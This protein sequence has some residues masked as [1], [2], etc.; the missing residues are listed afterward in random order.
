MKQVRVIK[1]LAGAAAM[2][3]ASQAYGAVVVDANPTNIIGH[4]PT[5][6]D[7]G[8]RVNIDVNGDGQRDL[9]I[10]YRN[11]SAT[12]G[13]LLLGYIYAGAGSTNPG[14]T[15]AANVSGQAYSYNLAAGTLVGAASSFY[16][17]AGYF[18]HLV[19]NYAGT[20]YGVGNNPGTPLNVGFE[21]HSTATAGSP[22]EYGYI[23]L[24]VDPYVSATNVGGIQFFKLAYDNAPGA[25]IA[26]GASAV[27]EPTSLAALAFGAAGLAGVGLKKRRQRAAQ[28]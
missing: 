27:P 5:S 10:L 13:T 9:S 22:L 8:T 25:N 3:G 18:G 28:V 11:I 14:A 23:S 15:V 26:V 24:E 19:T 4:A 16:Q 21:F 12:G 7:S 2:A 6:T 20:S 1:G 17:K